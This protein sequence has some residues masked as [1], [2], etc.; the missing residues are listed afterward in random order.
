MSDEPTRTVMRTPAW[1]GLVLALLALGYPIGFL[2]DRST[3]VPPAASLALLVGGLFLTWRAI[4]S[5]V[6][7]QSD[8]IVDRFVFRT[9]TIPIDDV[10]N[11][12]PAPEEG[13]RL[14]VHLTNGTRHRFWLSPSY[15]SRREQARR[16]LE[17]SLSGHR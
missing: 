7:V 17:D 1:A 14:H 13:G 8:R 4:T 11:V 9:V 3:N 5:R 6:V 2:V 12:G 15:G 16:I 10:E